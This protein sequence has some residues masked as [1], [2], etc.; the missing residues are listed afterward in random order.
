MTV[1]IGN[2]ME[3]EHRFLGTPCTQ[4]EPA[5]GQGVVFFRLRPGFSSCNSFP[6]EACSNLAQPMKVNEYTRK[7]IGRSF[8]QQAPKP[9]NSASMHPNVRFCKLAER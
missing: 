2:S 5:F 1:F 9:R 7:S 3:A 8:F 4:A 6:R